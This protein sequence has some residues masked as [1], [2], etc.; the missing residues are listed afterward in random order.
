MARTRRPARR[1]FFPSLEERERS[2][3][4]RVGGVML[5]S[6][7]LML[8]YWLGGGDAGVVGRGV[9]WLLREVLGGGSYLVFPALFLPGLF[10][11]A[12]RGRFL[13]RSQL[14]GGG[15][16]FGLGP[17][18]LSAFGFDG[19]LWG[20]AV[21]R[22]IRSALGTGGTYIFLA[23][24]GVGA[25]VLLAEW[26]PAGVLARLAALSRRLFPRTPPSRKEA[27]VTAGAEAEEERA[28][29][30]EQVEREEPGKEEGE[31]REPKEPEPL[32]GEGPAGEGSSGPEPL[33]LPLPE[34][35]VYELPPLSLLTRS[36]PERGGKLRRELEERQR[37]LE[38]TLKDFGVEARILG[39]ERGPAVTRFE[40]HPGPG[41]KVSRITGLSEDIAVRLGVPGVRVVSPVPGKRCLGIEVPNQEVGLVYL[42]DVLESQEFRRSASPLTIA[43]GE[44]ISGQPVVSTL[45]KMLHLLIA[46]ATGS[47]KSACI[48][49][50]LGS[51]LFKA[52]PRELRL[53]LVDPKRV[54][55]LPY[56]GLPHLLAPVVTD[57]RRVLSVLRWLCQEMERRYH[58][59]AAGGVRD[60]GR[61]NQKAQLGEG[62]FL[63]FIVVVIDELADLMMV[64]PREV[65]DAIQRLA[66]MARAAGIHLILATQRPSVDVITGVIKANIPSRIAFAVSSQVDSRTILDVPGA[67]KLLGKGDMLF[68]PLGMPAPVRVQ[69]A[70]LPEKDLEALLSHVRSQGEPE[71]DARVSL[72][73]EEGGTGEE[74][75]D[76]LFAEALR[77][78]MET[79]Q[80]SVSILQRRLRI[81]YSRAGRLI[82]LMERR[83]FVGPHQGSRPREIFITPE[84]YSRL[85][86]SS[87]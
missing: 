56:N 51:L 53:I 68:H 47:G 30:E 50:I 37:I 12:G 8:L 20:R 76:E 23:A 7:G 75:E 57:P 81:G 74:E 17:V 83:G 43:L 44:D 15:L 42:R 71:Y 45:E 62:E 32:P 60:I 11:M 31:E 5:A 35:R 40:L 64:A 3:L 80:A 78:V 27:P 28:E 2:R 79:G 77:V 87:T 39:V 38:A 18:V 65:E 6:A 70:Y 67:E 55:L 73:P 46:G 84:A 72:L 36:S 29:R 48:N 86:R 24:W 66:Q 25:V 63:P 33:Q 14:V 4:E 61:H 58:L 49:S 85:F 9:K 82:D 22:L 34:R 21:F 19:G 59:F 26:R 41:V 13:G 1:F 54:E 16:I 52:T 69:G 10:L